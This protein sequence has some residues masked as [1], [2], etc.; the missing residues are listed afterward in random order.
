MPIR[1]QPTLSTVWVRDSK[2]DSGATD[3]A[4]DSSVLVE[5]TVTGV[6]EPPA[7]SGDSSP[8]HAENDVG[9][10][11][12]YADND[13]E[14]ASITWTLSGDDRGDFLISETGELTFKNTPDFETPVD[15]DKNNIY[16]VTLT[17]DDG[18]NT[19]TFDVTV[20]V[21][22]VNE[23]PFFPAATAARSVPENTPVGQNIGLPVAARDWDADTTLEYTLGGA[24][25]SSFDF[26][27]ATGQLKT[28]VA[29]DH[30]SKASYTVTVS[31]TDGEDADGSTDDAVD[32]S[33]TVTINVTGANDPP[34]ISGISTLTYDEN[35][36][37]DVATY[38]ATDQ[39]SGDTII[40]RLSGNDDGTLSLSSSGVLTFDSPPDFEAPQDRGTDS[41]DTGRDNEY[42]V[43]V[44]AFD[45]TATTT[46]DVTI[47][48]TNV[49]EAG[50]L[51][52]TKLQPQVGT[53]LTAKI[54][55]PDNGVSATSWEWEI[56]DDGN[57]NLD[58]HHWSNIPGIHAASSRRGQVPA[59]HRD[60]HRR[61]DHQQ[62]PHGHECQRG[63]GRADAQHRAGV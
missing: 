26:D 20:T 13:P 29:L 39:D 63:P 51:I 61:V 50:E 17:A 34:V 45:G 16:L 30:E 58:P 28:K 15:K 23:P 43:T 12:D 1:K 47:T 7:I 33:V 44:E 18:T 4:D 49:D 21:E 59:G 52:F 2:D 41:Q 22:N 38:T 53:E 11:A 37:S 40:W 24:D 3:T 27:T 5:I 46:L 9:A 56:S 60:L 57:T 10:V 42:L 54:V 19:D 14:D 62:D 31:V 48:V 36:T 55:D 25:D 32:D 6:D 35:A 8:N